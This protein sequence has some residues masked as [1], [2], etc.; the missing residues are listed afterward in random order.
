MARAH[1]RASDEMR[2]V[3]RHLT[4]RLASLFAAGVQCG[5]CS[6]VTDVTTAAEQA[7]AL[8]AASH[9]CTSEEGAQQEDG[10]QQLTRE[11]TTAAGDRQ[12]RGMERVS[13]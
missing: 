3:R 8:H 10:G 4:P 1:A 6:V 13:T 9:E 2:C 5:A 7:H 11:V 12:Q